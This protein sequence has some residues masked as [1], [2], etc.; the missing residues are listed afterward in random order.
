[1]LRLPII[2]KLLQDRANMKSYLLAPMIVM[3]ALCQ[4]RL[5]RAALAHRNELAANQTDNVQTTTSP[6]ARPTLNAAATS[7]PSGQLAS[8]SMDTATSGSESSPSFA[9]DSYEAKQEQQLAQQASMAGVDLYPNH[10]NYPIEPYPSASYTSLAVSSTPSSMSMSHQ[11]QL[12]S[13]LNRDHHDSSA[14]VANI[15]PKP[16]ND[17]ANLPEQSNSSASLY[18]DNYTNQA[19]IDLQDN[20]DLYKQQLIDSSGTSSLLHTGL[21]QNLTA[22]LFPAKQASNNATLS[23]LS[24]LL[25]KTKQIQSAPPTSTAHSYFG[26]PTSNPG[27][28][29]ATT[30]TGTYSSIFSI[31]NPQATSASLLESQ[32]SSILDQLR[33]G[34][35]RAQSNSGQFGFRDPRQQGRSEPS[36]SSGFFSSPSAK[37]ATS[38][39]ISDHKSTLPTGPITGRYISDLAG[40]TQTS[41]YKSAPNIYSTYL[42]FKDNQINSQASSNGPTTLNMATL[43]DNYLADNGYKFPLVVNNIKTYQQPTSELHKPSASQAVVRNFNTNQPGSNY[44]YVQQHNSNSQN[45]L[46]KIIYHSTPFRPSIVSPPQSITETAGARQQTF[47]EGNKLIPFNLSNQVGAASDDKR[48]TVYSTNGQAI[49]SNRFSK[50][51]TRLNSGELGGDTLTSHTTSTTAPSVGTDEL[52]FGHNFSQQS[53]SLR[54]HLHN[55]GSTSNATVQPSTRH[56]TQPTGVLQPDLSHLNLDTNQKGSHFNRSDPTILGAST[57]TQLSSSSSLLFDLYEREIDSQIQEALYGDQHLSTPFMGVVRPIPPT[58]ANLQPSPSTSWFEKVAPSSSNIYEESVNGNLAETWSKPLTLSNQA[59]YIHPVSSGSRPNRYLSSDS[60]ATALHELPTFSTSDLQPLYA[61][62]P[63]YPL[64]ATSNAQD[65]LASTTS[66]VSALT[67]HLMSGYP[68]HVNQLSDSTLKLSL[69]DGLMKQSESTTPMPIGTTTASTLVSTTPTPSS[70]S[71]WPSILSKLQS[72]PLSSLLATPLAHFYSRNR[73]NKKQTQQQ[74]Q[75]SA[76]SQ[77]VNYISQPTNNPPLQLYPMLNAKHLLSLLGGASDQ[78]SSTSS[79]AQS[80]LEPQLSNN[81][82]RIKSQQMAQLAANLLAAASESSPQQWNHLQASL[83]QPISPNPYLPSTSE[84][85]DLS[86][87]LAGLSPSFSSSVNIHDGNFLAQAS[88][89]AAN[90]GE[91]SSVAGGAG[92]AL[93][94]AG[95]GISP[96]IWR[97]I[98]SPATWARKQSSSGSSSIGAYS[99]ANSTASISNSNGQNNKETPRNQQTSSP[100]PFTSLF[101]SSSLQTQHPGSHKANENSSSY[102]QPQ[103]GTKGKLSMPLSSLFGGATSHLFGQPAGGLAS[104]ASGASLL[105]LINS[106][107]EALKRPLK[108]K[109]KILR[110]PV[111][112]YDHS[113]SGQSNLAIGQQAG[114]LTSSVKYTSAVEP[115]AAASHLQSS[116]SASLLAGMNCPLPHT[117][118]QQLIPH[119]FDQHLLMTSN[120]AAGASLPSNLVQMSPLAGTASNNAPT[121]SSPPA[122]DLG[123]MLNSQAS[124]SSSASSLDGP[125][126]LQAEIS[127]TSDLLES[128][129]SLHSRS[130]YAKQ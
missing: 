45:H 3:I 55:S 37:L 70:S 25:N 62:S 52:E 5:L 11:Q 63:G 105:P 91:G 125:L 72:S 57:P 9:R 32:Y 75:N 4:F 41:A 31:N 103:P 67:P 121:R 95:G 56:P 19:Q 81:N 53:Q 34:Q 40:L 115:S 114:G 100:P 110:I 130:V 30:K 112:V 128:P 8:S 73:N 78:P 74:Q 38:Y 20:S 111:A 101:S 48:Q 84:E 12:N 69:V 98:F 36:S 44:H 2:L 126:G 77:T 1:M 50:D 113:V 33:S 14:Q 23:T 42:P 6:T 129:S 17:F 35:P 24:E 127:Q 124:T 29:S 102:N 108:L 104:H 28:N 21:L 99:P 61:S 58:S 47:P 88:V 85:Q 68:A 15:N 117:S 89:A 51:N 27:K 106:Q 13:L 120:N 79:N 66:M 97:S 119:T 96:F 109:I 64:L 116:L 87:L 16:P 22:S 86:S 94:L 83:V 107:M 76:A 80:V 123:F 10:R 60:L 7:S 26:A 43:Y 71:V 54:S 39:Q 90:N 65:S 49:T 18:L 59:G 46:D 122:P 92:G 82:Q 118:E 93:G